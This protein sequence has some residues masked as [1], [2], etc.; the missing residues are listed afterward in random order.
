L[1]YSWKRKRV[2]GT[3][4]VETGVV[5]AHPKLPAGLG[6]DNRVGKPPWVVN[7]P[8]KNSVE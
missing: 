6:D 1:T 5:D 2:F 3:S 7:L 4:L 8:D